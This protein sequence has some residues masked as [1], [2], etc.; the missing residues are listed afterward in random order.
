MSRNL[1]P[2]GKIVRRLGINI[3]GNPKFDRLL[4]RRPNPPGEAKKRR[5]RLSEY[6]KQ[7][8]EKQK[9]RFSYG[10]TE[11]Q[12]RIVFRNAKKVKGVTGDNMLILLERRLDNIIYRLGMAATR[13]QARQ[14]V[15]HGHIRVNNRR[16]DIPSYVVKTND[17]VGVKEKDSSRKLLQE[18]IA[19]NIDRE[20]PEWLTLSK[21][22]MTGKIN[23]LPEKPD[24]PIVGDEQLV[25]EFYSK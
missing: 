24:I 22:D 17:I 13:T 12:F 23:R 8:V 16:V 25:V 20:I 6:G 15:N 21:V 3:F 14:I 10:L 1:D 4:E 18:L 11:K 7:L 2:K 5:P 9:I 19:G